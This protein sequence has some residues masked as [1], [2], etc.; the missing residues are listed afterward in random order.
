[1]NKK[2]KSNLNLELCDFLKDYCRRLQPKTEKTAAN[3]NSNEPIVLKGSEWD[4]ET[5]KGAKL[6]VNKKEQDQLN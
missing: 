6:I 4:K 2:V 5:K 1:M 3:S